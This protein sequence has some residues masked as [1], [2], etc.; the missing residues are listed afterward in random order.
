MTDSTSSMDLFIDTNILLAFYHFSSDDLEELWKLAVLLQKGRLRLLLPE[1]VR[2]EF[3]RNREGRIAESLKRLRELPLKYQFPQLCKEYSEYEELRE[4]QKQMSD[5]HSKPIEQ[6]EEDE[7]RSDLKPDLILKE[8]FELAHPIERTPHLV[9]RAEMRV[10]IG[11]PPGKSGS[12]GDAINW[13]SILTLASEGQELAIITDD[14]DYRSPIDSKQFNRML[15]DEWESIS[16]TS[17]QYYERLSE[18]FA[19]RHPDIKLA[20]ELENDILI[21]ELA[22][23]PNFLTIHGIIARLNGQEFTAAQ[24]NEIAEA[25]LSNSQVLWIIQ[26]QDVHDFLTQI[27]NNYGEVLDSSN[28]FMLLSELEDDNASEEPPF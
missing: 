13:E 24:A 5:H 28:Y 4:L 11:N 14:R 10:R 3:D 25:A 7:A 20:S 16:D 22:S 26:D 1:Q 2:D 15:A 6:I 21:S 18:F 27:L 17:L 12:L 23:S 19:D 8:L 9:E